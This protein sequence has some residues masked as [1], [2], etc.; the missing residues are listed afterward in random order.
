MQGTP[1]DLSRNGIDFVELLAKLEEE[2]GDGESSI[3]TSGK[4]SRRD[5]RA[6]SRSI[7]SSSQSLDDFDD[8]TI[9]EGD[10]SE[11]EKSKSPEDNQNIEM[12]S[13]GVVQ[14]SVLLNYVRCG[15]NPVIVFGLL[16]LFIATQI[17]ASG[18]DFWVAYWTSQEEQRIFLRQNGTDAVASIRANSSGV[19]EATM[20]EGDTVEEPLLSTDL[21]MAVHGGL[22][23]S[24]FLIAISR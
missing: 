11:K 22:V 16:L 17:A 1:H 9:G 4:R 7:A 10:K 3:V 23:I 19:L 20:P 18:A 13:K 12:S 6:S 24:V 21:C 5:S 8:E 2:T 14:G 15:A